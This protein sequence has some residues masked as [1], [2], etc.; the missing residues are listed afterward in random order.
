[1]TENTALL[2]GLDFE[3]WLTTT[4]EAREALFKY[5][6]SEPPTDQDVAIQNES[7]ACDLR[8]D[9]EF[10]L[11][12]ETAKQTLKVAEDYEELAAPERRLIVK[13]NVANVKRIVDG[14]TVAAAIIRSKLYSAMNQARAK[15]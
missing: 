7:M 12:Q 4:V 2:N 13:A 8:D 11:T 14:L 10:Y 1:M 3:E 6:K 9:A 5:C 15:A